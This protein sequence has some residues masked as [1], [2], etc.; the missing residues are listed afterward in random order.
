[1]EYLAVVPNYNVWR[2]WRIRTVCCL[3][4]YS[5]DMYPEARSSGTLIAYVAT[6]HE[7]ALPVCAWPLARPVHG[8][9][10]GLCLNCSTT[11]FAS[12]FDDSRFEM[13]LLAVRLLSV[14][15]Y[16]AKSGFSNGHSACFWRVEPYDFSKTLANYLST[17]DSI[18]GS[19]ASLQPQPRPVSFF[20]SR[21]LRE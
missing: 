14:G 19:Q 11:N 2:S 5:M 10:G 20:Q 3:Y 4:E 7:K 9:K 15:E 21:S 12:K 18:Q 6:S 8:I 1:M 13:L 16:Q 17:T